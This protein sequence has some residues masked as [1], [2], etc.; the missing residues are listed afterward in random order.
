MDHFADLRPVHLHRLK[1]VVN[2]QLEDPRQPR[3]T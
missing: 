1:R 3:Q 2:G